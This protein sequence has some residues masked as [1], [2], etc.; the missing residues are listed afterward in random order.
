MHNTSLRVIDLV[1]W[2]II[3]FIGFIVI[4]FLIVALVGSEQSENL[5]VNVDGQ[6]VLFIEPEKEK[7]MEFLSTGLDRLR[8]DETILNYGLGRYYFQF[9]DR[10]LQSHATKSIHGVLVLTNSRLILLRRKRKAGT[11][12]EYEYDQAITIPIPLIKYTD[13]DE[14]KIRIGTLK[15]IR[16]R[17]IQTFDFEIDSDTASQ[18]QTRINELM[19]QYQSIKRIEEA[20]RKENASVMVPLKC[21]K[22]GGHLQPLG[23]KNI[24]ECKFCGTTVIKT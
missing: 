18:W 21:P 14:N 23:E 13:K 17:K 2:L 3:G 10:S 7:W 5:Y 20:R 24:Y 4:L 9:Y 11:I 22:C 6:Q 16:G 19:M 1:E 15:T 8:Q 12:Q